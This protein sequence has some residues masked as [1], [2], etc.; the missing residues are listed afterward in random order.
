MLIRPVTWKLLS[1]T[2]DTTATS[3]TTT[4]IQFFTL[5]KQKVPN[6]RS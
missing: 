4:T 3:D 1:Y 5:K 2:S 6:L